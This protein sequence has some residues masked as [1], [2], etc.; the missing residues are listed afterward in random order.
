[1]G[2]RATEAQLPITIEGCLYEQIRRAVGKTT[3]IVESIPR[4]GETSLESI[5]YPAITLHEIIT[6]AVLHR[7]YSI[8]NDVHIRIFDNRI[9]VQSPGRLP[10][11]VTPERILQMRYA[12]NGAINRFL[13]RFP[14]PPNRD[15]GEGLR[16]AFKA[17][18]ELNLKEPVITEDHESVLVLIRHEP[19]GSAQELIMQ[20]LESNATI[21][22][23]QARKLTNIDSEYK[24]RKMFHDLESLNLIEHV[25][26]TSTSSSAWRKKIEWTSPITSELPPNVVQDES[27]QLRIEWEANV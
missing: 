16:A 11:G 14:D 23:S 27:G 21:R 22:N 12:R 3:E 10:A 18:H 9:E 5:T 19:L 1:M 17:M 6:N 4:M 24:I 13:N 20:F 26:G 15:I 25:P 8:P 2:D 7:D